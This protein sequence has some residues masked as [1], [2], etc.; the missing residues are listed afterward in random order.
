MYEIGK[1]LN[2][3]YR[4]KKPFNDIIVSQKFV[5]DLEQVYGEMRNGHKPKFT[6]I[7]VCTVLERYGIRTTRTSDGW[8]VA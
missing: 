7:D 5:K 4:G 1:L 3:L 8:A 2:K 6:N